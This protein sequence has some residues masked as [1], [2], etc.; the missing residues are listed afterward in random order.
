[1]HEISAYIYSNIYIDCF[2]KELLID[3]S[4]GNTTYTPTTLTKEE[5]LDNHRSVLWSCEIS[6]KDEELDLPSLYWTPNLQKCPFKLCYVDGSAKCSTK[7]ISKLSTCILAEAKTG[8]LSYWDT[9]YSW[10]G[11]NVDYEA[12]NIYVREHTI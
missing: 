1:M 8:L 7:L 6:T 12:L 4:L 9:N 3:N 10:G 2:L 11:S 5:I